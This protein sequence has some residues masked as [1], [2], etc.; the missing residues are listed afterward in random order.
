[1]SPGGKR[2]AEACA[3]LVADGHIGHGGHPPCMRSA[4]AVF[5]P[6]LLA[7]ALVAPEADAGPKPV[8]HDTTQPHATADRPVPRAADTMS[9]VG[10]VPDENKA[11]YLGYKG[12]ID[13][14]L[15]FDEFFAA[16]HTVMA[17][18]MPQYP[19]GDTGPIVAENGSGTYAFGQ[20]DY[21]EGD[22]GNGDAGS[23]VFFVQV[24]NKKV[25]YLLPEM[26]PGKWIHVAVV[27]KG[28]TVSLFVWGV[29]RTPV[30]V[31]NKSTNATSPAAE[32]EVSGASGLPSGKLRF[33]RRTNGSSGDKAT[34]QAY[35]L[36]DDIG[37]FT[38]ALNGSEIT[39][40][41]AAK[42]FKGSEGG[43]LAGYSFEK[44]PP[45]GNRPA[46][47]A[48]ASVD[49][50]HSRVSHAGRRRAQQHQRSRGVRQSVRD[51]CRVRGRAAAVQEER[52]VERDP[53]PGRP[54]QQ[55]QWLR[56]VLLRLH[57]RQQAADRRLPQWHRPCAGLRGCLRQAG[58]LSQ[59]RQLRRTP[60]ALLRAHPRRRER[61]HRLSAPRGRH[62]DRQG[63][64][65]QLQRRAR[66]RRAP[67]QCE[68]HQQG[69]AGRQ[70]GPEGS[71]SALQRRR[72][73]R[74]VDDDPDRVHQLRRVGRRRADVEPHPARPPEEG[75]ADSAARSEA[76]VYPS[77]SKFMQ[78][79]SMLSVNAVSTDIG[80]SAVQRFAV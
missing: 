25:R 64:R 54:G 76:G 61:A 19:H 52:G 45:G 36:I 62:L 30:V 42:R 4:S 9:K 16:D 53:G 72:R 69:R 80:T 32:I 73:A 15:G 78:A 29:K 75:A 39:S 58:R 66:L 27:R 8:A 3:G 1:M 44:K 48:V 38:K 50:R 41:I 14:D 57:G 74:G 35:G 60:R 18:Y 71:A 17:W 28:D 22:G 23:P 6:A 33:G 47:A 77:G 46:R 51:R 49:A 68:D 24:G 59:G 43:L 26:I 11:I 40:I 13:T 10:K 20:D 31:T 56:I 7:I 37:V 63:H 65:R 5:I 34:W 2:A 12:H 79:R 67:G 21:R 70:A 55:P